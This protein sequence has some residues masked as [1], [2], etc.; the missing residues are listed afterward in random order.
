V[1]E[2]DL[3]LMLSVKSSLKKDLDYLKE[4]QKNLAIITKTKAKLKSKIDPANFF[5]TEVHQT[6][7]LI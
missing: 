3:K 7:L 1:P 4:I 5:Q 2:I 6:T